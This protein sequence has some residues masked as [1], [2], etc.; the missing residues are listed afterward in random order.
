[1]NYSRV[2][3]VKMEMNHTNSKN[4]T[5]TRADKTAEELNKHLGIYD[6][7]YEYVSTY[8]NAI[9]TFLRKIIQVIFSLLSPKL[10]SI[11]G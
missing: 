10:Y 5:K 2:D 6:T 1:M 8:I 3:H 11:I 7:V 9:E 4:K